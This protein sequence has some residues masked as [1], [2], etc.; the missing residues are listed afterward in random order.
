MR[1]LWRSGALLACL[2]SACGG[3]F[4]AGAAAEAGDGGSAFGEGGDSGDTD[5]SRSGNPALG[6][7]AGS[8]GAS[9]AG[10]SGTELLSADGVACQAVDDCASGNC[11]DGFCCNTACAGCHACSSALTGQDDGKCAPVISGR[12]PH[13]ACADET[14][15]NECG[16]DGSCDGAGACSKIPPSHI[17]TPAGCSSDGK[18]FI[19]A[20]ACT[21]EGKCGIATAQACAPNS[22]CTSGQCQCSG[23]AKLSCGTC[24]TWNFESNSTEGWLKLND[25]TQSIVAK[26]TP[27]GAPFSGSA[28]SLAIPTGSTGIGIGRAVTVG[29]PFCASD[30]MVADKVTGFSLYVYMDGPEYA[31]GADFASTDAST[32]AKMLP[33]S[34]RWVPVSL[35]FPAASARYLKLTF[36]PPSNWVGTIYIDQVQIT[37]S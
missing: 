28:Y 16:N 29:V 6:G 34:R 14:A 36:G 35:T 31:L 30:G 11:V 5:I 19:A 12:D 32:N 2:G 27:P 10:A 3:S 22:S 24:S 7:E 8:G 13:A 4:H 17:C 18:S 25:T 15:T 23:G 9:N 26:P 1:R 21:G 20:T 37:T 33:V